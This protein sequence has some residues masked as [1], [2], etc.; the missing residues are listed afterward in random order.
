MSSHTVQGGD[1]FGI[2]ASAIFLPWRPPP[3]LAHAEPFFGCLQPHYPPTK[4]L[5]VKL[6]K[7]SK[8]GLR[9]DPI[10]CS[11]SGIE[12]NAH[13]TSTKMLT[14]GQA[15]GHAEAPTAPP[16]PWRLLGSKSRC[17]DVDDLID[18]DDISTLAISGESEQ[19]GSDNGHVDHAIDNNSGN[20]KVQKGLTVETDDDGLHTLM[21]RHIPC[22]CTEQEILDSIAEL[23]FGDLY[24]FLYLP[25]R[26]RFS[27]T[28]KRY[29]SQKFGYAFIGF[30]DAEVT[31]KFAEAITGYCFANRSSSNKSCEVVPARIQGFSGKGEH[32]HRMWCA[33]RK[34]EA[35]LTM[36]A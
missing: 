17:K 11:S 4:D 25:L 20:D 14:P 6:P 24:N 28:S 36:C 32:F 12:V 29:N 3:G 26:C 19:D 27:Q 31:N 9:G 10:F 16:M 34:T 2:Q 1:A 18:G 8:G 23:G 35:T 15:I 21:I 5:Q 33:R 22:S 7:S 13:P 30:P